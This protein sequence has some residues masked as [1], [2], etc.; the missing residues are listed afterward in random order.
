MEK[1]FNQVL[2][3]KKNKIDK[4][5]EIVKKLNFFNNESVILI[6]DRPE[7]LERAEEKKNMITTFRMCR[8]E[9]RYSDLICMDKDYEV[10]N[11]GEV[12]RIIKKE[13]MK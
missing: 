5:M 3:T 1:Y 12:A 13:K 7:Q 8:P 6:D 4:I 9:G 11:L 2:V 10:K